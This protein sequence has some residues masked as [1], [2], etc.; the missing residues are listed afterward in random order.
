MACGRPH[1]PWA[2]ATCLL[3]PLGPHTQGL[4]ELESEGL[5]HE[6]PGVTAVPQEP[7]L[8]RP[9][10]LERAAAPGLRGGKVRRTEETAT[11]GRDL[12]MVSPSA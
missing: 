12:Q 11:Q 4:E 1:R 8:L 5:F 2:F 6:G 10:G 3:W 7:L 9:G